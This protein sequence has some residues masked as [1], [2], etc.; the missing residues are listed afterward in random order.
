MVSPEHFQKFMTPAY[1]KVV[2][3]VKNYGIDVIIV[4]SDGLVDELIP[5]FLE[6]GVNGILPVEIAAGN[7]P[8]AWRKKYG[9]D[10]RMLGGIDK[11][12][13]SRGKKDI[14]D[15]LK[16]NSVLISESGYIPALDHL[17]PPDVSLDNFKYYMKLKREALK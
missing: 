2:K 4:D 10:L 15:E 6:V 14:E 5:L 16:K 17:I 1:K 13:L 12:A 9:K 7:D 11:R 8:I 3:F